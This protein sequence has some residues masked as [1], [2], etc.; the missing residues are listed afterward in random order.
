[1]FVCVKERENDNEKVLSRTF[2]FTHANFNLFSF[3]LVLVSNFTPEVALS[4]KM[5]NY[6]WL[7]NIGI[8]RRLLSNRIAGKFGEVFYL[9]NQVKIAEL[10]TRQ[11]K[12]NVCAPM[13]PSIQIAKFKFRQYQL[14]AV[15]PNLMLARFT[16]YTVYTPSDE[17]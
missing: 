14:R 16:R 2:F 8:E 7:R 13:T 6:Y 15:S 5:L 4:A 1:M 11:S 17:H 9:A 10:K 12:L 3:S